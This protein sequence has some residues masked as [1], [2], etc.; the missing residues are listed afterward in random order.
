MGLSNDDSWPNKTSLSKH[1]GSTFAFYKF[2][3]NRQKIY[4][5]RSP[6]FRLAPGWIQIIFVL[7]VFFLLKKPRSCS[8]AK[9]VRSGWIEKKYFESAQP[10]K[11]LFD[12]TP[13]FDQKESISTKERNIWTEIDQERSLTNLRSISCFFLMFDFIRFGFRFCASTSSSSVVPV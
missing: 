3:S 5:C 8:T 10:R 6:R 2:R 7:T 13:L 1:T 11:K 12:F 9:I 4:F